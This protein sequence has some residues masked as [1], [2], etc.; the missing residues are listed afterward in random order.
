[1]ADKK[2]PKNRESHDY[3]Q[4]HSYEHKSWHP[5]LLHEMCYS[6]KG[7]TDRHFRSRTS[8]EPGIPESSPTGHVFPR[9]VF[10]FH[11]GDWGIREGYVAGR[12]PLPDLSPCVFHHG[13]RAGQFYQPTF[14]ASIETDPP[15]TPSTGN[16]TGSNDVRVPAT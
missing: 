11:L 7:F 15:S 5:S 9:S 3:P 13:F 4:Q 6:G 14:I 10:R 16:V 1:M 12:N 8:R 2:N